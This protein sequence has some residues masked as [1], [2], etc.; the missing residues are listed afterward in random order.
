MRST[1]EASRRERASADL[2]DEH[3]DLAI[4]GASGRHHRETTLWRI[5]WSSRGEVDHVQ[6]TFGLLDHAVQVL[7]GGV[8]AHRRREDVR[9]S[10]RCSPTTASATTAATKV[11]ASPTNSRVRWPNRASR[12]GQEAQQ[13]EHRQHLAAVPAHAQQEG[14][15]ARQRRQRA[16][17][18]HLAHVLRRERQ[19]AGSPTRKQNSSCSG[20]ASG[21]ARSGRRS[22]ARW[23]GVGSRHRVSNGPAGDV[24]KRLPVGSAA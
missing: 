20:R 16:G 7:G 15:R 14:G 24:K 2:E 5:A 4:R 23:R 22:S 12:R 11:P 19:D 3:L 21:G 9:G 17:A 10:T 18:D 8:P 13:V 6:R 1:C